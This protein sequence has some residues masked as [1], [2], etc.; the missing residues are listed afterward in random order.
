[1]SEPD[2]YLTFARN[3]FEHRECRAMAE[4]HAQK[5]QRRVTVDPKQPAGADNVICPHG[6]RYWLVPAGGSE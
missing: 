3:A 6:V 1:M 2:E 5:T 4:H